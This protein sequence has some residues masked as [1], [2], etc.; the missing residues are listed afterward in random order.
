MV[1]CCIHKQ[2][3]CR[4]SH[5]PEMAG[6]YLPW[7][8]FKW[9]LFES[10]IYYIYCLD[11][12]VS[13]HQHTHCPFSSKLSTSPHNNGYPPLFSLL[14]HLKLASQVP[15]FP[16]KRP[17]PSIPQ[18]VHLNIT[19]SYLV[20]HNRAWM[21][22]TPVKTRQSHSRRTFC[23][24]IFISNEETTFL[25]A[26]GNS[27]R[28]CLNPATAHSRPPYPDEHVIFVP[29]CSPSTLLLKMILCN[30]LF[31]G[32]GTRNRIDSKTECKQ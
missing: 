6:H 11:T 8:P 20:F 24:A 32:I 25:V 10:I 23:P 12:Q 4:V 1:R 3:D 18:V 26:H 19:Q 13:R 22:I 15:E 2:S 21:S 30:S 14:C 17:A 9:Q 28:Q 31:P 5:D 16:L 27:I 29:G 7:N